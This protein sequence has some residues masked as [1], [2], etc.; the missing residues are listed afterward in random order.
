MYVPYL[1]DPDQV[2]KGYALIGAEITKL[3]SRTVKSIAGFI[4][5]L[6]VKFRPGKLSLNS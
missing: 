6:L 5:L 2:L 4:R 1:G 3:V